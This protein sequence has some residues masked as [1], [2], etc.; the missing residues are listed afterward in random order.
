MLATTAPITAIIVGHAVVGSLAVF[1]VGS[2]LEATQGLAPN[3]LH[4][5]TTDEPI[6]G[7]RS[8]AAAWLFWR[9]YIVDDFDM[10]P[11]HAHRDVSG[12]QPN[13]NSP[14]FLHIHFKLMPHQ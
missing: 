1:G 4:F 8:Y 9:G 2:L 10:A 7:L 14:N 13:N 5:V 3:D 11:I 12:V 6:L